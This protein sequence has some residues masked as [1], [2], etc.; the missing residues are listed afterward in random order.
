MA[1]NLKLCSGNDVDMKTV[2]VVKLCTGEVLFNTEDV[3]RMLGGTWESSWDQ[4]SLTIDDFA[5]V[6]KK[7]MPDGG[8]LLVT[9]KI[10]KHNPW[11]DDS[12]GGK[13]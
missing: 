3:I 2:R 9:F 4:E 10:V 6:L 7:M 8:D 13:Y 1:G 5:D 12:P 11:S